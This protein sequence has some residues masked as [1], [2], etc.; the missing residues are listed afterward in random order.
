MM[1]GGTRLVT[2]VVRPT[3]K[4]NITNTATVFSGGPDTNSQNDRSSA[5]TTVN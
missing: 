2:I 5:Q 1:S 3:R 4:V